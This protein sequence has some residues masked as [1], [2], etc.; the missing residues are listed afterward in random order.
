[1]A[2]NTVMLFVSNIL[3]MAS[4]VGIAAVGCKRFCGLSIRSTPATVDLSVMLNLAAG[5]GISIV[6]GESIEE[7][8]L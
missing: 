6:S 8:E 4:L 1:M 2:S 3:S 5:E 7:R